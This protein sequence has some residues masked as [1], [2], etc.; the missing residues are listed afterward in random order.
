MLLIL[1]RSTASRHRFSARRV[2]TSFTSSRRRPSAGRLAGSAAAAS[3]DRHEL[4]TRS[5]RPV[6]SSSQP[7]SLLERLDTPGASQLAPQPRLGPGKRSVFCGCCD[8]GPATGQDLRS[9]GRGPS[10]VI[11]R[12]Y[13]AEVSELHQLGAS[14]CHLWTVDLV[15]T[16]S[17]SSGHV[18]DGDTGGTGGFR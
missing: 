13:H 2:N 17:V 14:S 3:L 1:A 18:G 12:N 4:H 11:A 15:A 16:G 9:I 7:R 8:T 6:P 5:V 10:T